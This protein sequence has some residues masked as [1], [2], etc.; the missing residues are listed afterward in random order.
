[1]AVRCGAGNV[2]PAFEIIPIMGIVPGD[3]DREFSFLSAV[4]DYVFK[5]MDDLRQLCT[6]N[7]K[8]LPGRTG[9]GNLSSL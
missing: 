1:M 7:G 9:W 6:G 4:Y 3:S 5:C 2:P 8:Y